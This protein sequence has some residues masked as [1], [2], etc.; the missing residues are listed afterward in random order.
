LHAE[1]SSDDVSASIISDTVHS[2]FLGYPLG[3][4]VIRLDDRYEFITS[5]TMTSFDVLTF[6]VAWDS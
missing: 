1:D 2:D 3:G 4:P 5:A 6:D